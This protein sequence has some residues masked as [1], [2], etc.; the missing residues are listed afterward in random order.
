MN[1]LVL[2]AAEV[3]PLVT[4]RGSARARATNAVGATAPE[5]LAR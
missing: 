1:G 2:P 5:A 3:R 4:S